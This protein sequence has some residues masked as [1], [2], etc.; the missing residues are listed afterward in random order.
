LVEAAHE[1]IS[2][3]NH[4]PHETTLGRIYQQQTAAE[5]TKYG[6]YRRFSGMAAVAV[7]E[8]AA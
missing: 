5:L 2:V 6:G 8:T 3:V 7:I 1:L 4:Q